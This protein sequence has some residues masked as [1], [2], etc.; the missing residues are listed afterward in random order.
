MGS[1][2]Y[3]IRHVVDIDP[4][5]GLVLFG[6]IGEGA[7][8]RVMRSDVDSLTNAAEQAASDAI[9]ALETPPRGALVFSCTARAMVFGK[10]IVKEPVAISA[11]LGM[12]PV[13]GFLTY[14]E[15]ARVMGASGFHNATVAVLVF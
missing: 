8:V 9:A 13:G 12:A 6:H 11:G 5:G 2:G 14:G 4:D 15:F 1:G 10:E 3:E 7:I